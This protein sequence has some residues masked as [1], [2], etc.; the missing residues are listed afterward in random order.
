MASQLVQERIERLDEVLK[1]IVR[2]YPRLKRQQDIARELGYSRK[3]TLSDYKNPELYTEKKFRN[4]VHLLARVYRIDPGYVLEGHGTLFVIPET[5]MAE[6][7]FPYEPEQRRQLARGMEFSIQVLQA[8]IRKYREQLSR[9]ESAKA[10]KK[11]SRRN[12]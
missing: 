11:P 12:A 3:A 8:Q 5:E 9:L 6:V 7:P 1:A 10:P 4:F 2:A